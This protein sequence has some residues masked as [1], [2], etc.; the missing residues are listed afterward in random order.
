MKE[1]QCKREKISYFVI[2]TSLFILMSVI[3]FYK[4]WENGVSF[5]WKVDGW[6]QHIH[7]IQ[8]Y[9]NWL[10]QIVKNIFIY[11]KWEIPLWSS[12]IGFGSDII[13]ILHYYV[14]GEPLNLLY[15]FIPDKYIVH[16][17]DF[18]ILFRIY[19]TGISFSLFCFYRKKNNKMAVLTGSLIYMF[20]AYIILLGFHHPF[21]ITPFMYLPLLLLGIEKILDKKSSLCFILMVFISTISNFYFMYMIA[22]NAVIYLIV[23]LIMIYGIRD[24]KEL[25]NKLVCFVLNAIIGIC[26]GG[27]ILLPILNLFTQN[28]R[29]GSSTGFQ[30]LYEKEFYQKLSKMFIVPSGGLHHTILGFSC[31]VFF[32]LYLLYTRRKKNMELKINFIL[33]T[34]FLCCPAAGKVF[35]GFSYP[36]NRWIFGYILLLSYIVV[37]EWDELFN[38]G[39]KRFFGLV[40]IMIIFISYSYYKNSPDCRESIKIYYI[41]FCIG[42]VLT[43]VFVILNQF[44]LNKNKF[45]DYFMQLIVL[46]LVITS[47]NL[48][49]HKTFYFTEDKVNDKYFIPVEKVRNN[50]VS[51]IDKAV[52]KISKND[53]S[54]YRYEGERSLVKRNSTL[55]SGLNSTN[56]Y[57]SLADKIP[58]EFLTEIGLTNKQGYNYNGLDGRTILNE[59]SSTKYYVTSFKKSGKYTIPY[60]FKKVQDSKIG[61]KKY[62]VFENEYALP[63]GYTYDS[64]YLR[65]E[66]EKMSEVER[67]NA[68]LQ[69]V[70]LEKPC[71]N[72]SKTQISQ[73]YL[74]IPYQIKECDGVQS[75]GN[76]FEVKKDGGF[77]KLEVQQKIKNC[78][79]NLLVENIERKQNDRVIDDNMKKSLYEV[80]T[81]NSNGETLKNIFFYL[82]P[83]SLRYCGRTHFFVNLGYFKSGRQTVIFKFPQKGHYKIGTLKVYAQSMNQYPQQVSKLKENVMENV[84]IGTNTIQGNI[85]L[86]NDKIL[87]LSVPYSKGWKAIV[88]GKEQKILQANTMYMA[89]PLKKGLH[90]IQLRYCTPGLKEGIILSFVGLGMCIVVCSY[91]KKVK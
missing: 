27:F 24:V 4:F 68:L 55:Q 82:S 81:I 10:Q 9:S 76:N 90:K 29:E 86:N 50:I 66:Y 38:M 2:Y 80:R 3:L 20:S 69:G 8:F 51:N 37:V 45:M 71:K 53:K 83:N 54:F 62:S 41:L 77:V 25:L 32:C 87:F 12:S 57:W 70:M 18:M 79:M 60:G 5:V 21:F 52:L 91:K 61:G 33:L 85:N 73:N 28:S 56:F 31:I 39:W 19:L 34:L 42:L 88:D 14:I 13:T 17:Y 58:G 23:R 78:E 67:Q 64:Y 63:I 48:H 74:E 44:K 15:V 75:A 43:G 22:L 1:I 6:S 36:S 26:M 40:S 16:A 49:V 11:H 59:M 35:N 65:S 72:Y 84:E 46:L 89:L 47:V 7:A 30:L